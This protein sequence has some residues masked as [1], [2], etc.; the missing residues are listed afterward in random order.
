MRI[1]N[2]LTLALGLTMIGLGIAIF[3]VTVVQGG[4][5]VGIILGTLFVAAGAGRL[6]VQGKR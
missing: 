3:V 1:Y 2:G 6:Y 4:G 5:V